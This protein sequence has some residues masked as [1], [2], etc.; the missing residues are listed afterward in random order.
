MNPLL[1]VLRD[2]ST[3]FSSSRTQKD[4]KEELLKYLS[5]ERGFQIFFEKKLNLSNINCIFPRGQNPFSSYCLREKNKNSLF[6][7][8]CRHKNC[9]GPC[10][11]KHNGKNKIS[12]LLSVTR[13]KLIIFNRLMVILDSENILLDYREDNFEQFTENVFQ[14]N[15]GSCPVLKLHLMESIYRG[16][17]LNEN[18]CHSSTP[19]VEHEIS[20]N[21]YKENGHVSSKSLMFMLSC[22]YLPIW[23]V[24]TI[25]FMMKVND[26]MT[27]LQIKEWKQEI[28][29]LASSLL[30]YD[31]KFSPG[32]IRDENL[33]YKFE[34][35]ILKL[36]INEQRRFKYLLNP[37]QQVNKRN[38]MLNSYIQVS[39]L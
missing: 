25:Y 1:L 8:E 11:F 6:Q 27:N 32:T 3:I 10:L 4:L 15:T 37:E 17:L 33:I 22:S 34:T 13:F 31:D 19:K 12:D 30:K 16:N 23:I 5:K 14:M 38:I 18:N 9:Q 7:K 24:D 29:N 36:S 20:I 28:H 2:L 21:L 39:E 35:E 26:Q